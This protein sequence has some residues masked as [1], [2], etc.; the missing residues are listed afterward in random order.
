MP[1]PDE[2]PIDWSQPVEFVSYGHTPDITGSRG[3][4]ELTGWEQ[5][6]Y[7][8]ACLQGEMYR[9]EAAERLDLFDRTAWSLA[10]ALLGP[11]TGDETGLTTS[12]TPFDEA[13]RD[14][15][16][17][18]RV[19][20][21]NGTLLGER[22]KL[23]RARRAVTTNPDQAKLLDYD[24]DPMLFFQ[25]PPGHPQPGMAILDEETCLGRFGDS[26]RG[27]EAEWRSLTRVQQEEAVAD[28]VLA[29]DTFQR[30]QDGTPVSLVRAYGAPPTAKPTT[31]ATPPGPRTPRWKAILFRLVH[32]VSGRG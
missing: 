18:E 13:T 14:R 25:S 32:I 19:L 7:I 28:M 2:G 12:Y 21:L 9:A 24:F 5:D 4:F 30:A 29:A 11:L 16:L 15:V 26:T 22:L 8:M 3:W 10:R 31:P 17:R 27:A 1:S 6:E 23:A 20:S